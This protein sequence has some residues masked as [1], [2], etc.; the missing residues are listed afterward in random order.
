MKSLPRT[1]RTA[2]ELAVE[3]VYR[4]TE[5]GAF[6]AVALDAE[7][8]RARL[9]ARDAAL[10]TEIVYGTLRSVPALDRLIAPFLKRDLSRMDALTR[11]ALRAAVYQL[12]YLAR[13]PAYA[14]LDET[15]R[16]LRARRDGRTAGFA[17]AVLRRVAEVCAAGEPPGPPRLELPGWVEASL[18]ASLSSERVDKFLQ[19]QA[20]VPPIGLRAQAPDA[21][22]AELAERIRAARPQAR[23]ELGG[24]SERALLVWR[25]G[26]PRALPGY[27]EGALSVQ[28]EGAQA[29]GASLGV[30]AGE[31]VADLCA[32]HGGKSLAFAE[33]LGA[34]G[35]VLAVDLDE[36]K[37]ERIDAER[38]RLRL[39]DGCIATR[40]I[41]LSV[42]VGSL[43]GDFDRVMVDA[44]CT[45]LG[46]LHRRPELLLRRQPDDVER[47]GR[48][49]LA[50]LERAV[51]LVRPGG[52]LAYAVCSPLA[53][54]GIEVVRALE[55]RVA[56][57]TRVPLEGG[58]MA[59]AD[60]DAVLRIGPWSAP[61]TASAPDAYQVVQ[62]LRRGG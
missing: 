8:S 18:R 28:E 40:A 54:E 14:V 21:D 43:S 47:L 15:V 39:P 37:L 42:G 19:L 46:T 48:L 58:L 61:G 38:R 60:D 4:A 45:G 52:R 53:A 50:I 41:D 51:E 6:A 29:V 13:V 22:R 23:V 30:R 16:L 9:D 36:R 11:A 35:R 49:Q 2:R 3:V 1:A 27:A 59:H 25:A 17:N 62:W 57:I 5:Q 24:L 32:G 20:I 55:A 56:G 7:L 44:P 12:R 33:Q 31:R 10:A 34:D 26:D